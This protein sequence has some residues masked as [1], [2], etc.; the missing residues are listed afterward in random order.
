MLKSGVILEIYPRSYKSGSGGP[1]GDL[2]GIIEKLDYLQW[3]G[4]EHIWL[5]PIYP[6]PMQD[7]GY[8]VTDYYAIHEM[9]GTLADFD[10]LVAKARARGIGIIMDLVVNHTSIEHEWFR[11]A[12]SSPT[13]PYRDRYIFRSRKEDGR[14]PNNHRSMFGGTAWAPVPGEAGVY[15][16]H[17]F[18]TG[19]ADLNYSHPDVLDEM[20]RIMRYWYDRGVRGIRVDVVYFIG[21]DPELPDEPLNPHWDGVDPYEELSHTYTQF[22]PLMFRLM[23]Q[24][25]DVAAEYGDRFVIYEAYP[26]DGTDHQL[27]HR[28]YHA[29]DRQHAA[30]FHFGLFFAKWTAESIKHHVEGFLAGLPDGSVPIWNVSN[31]DQHRIASRVGSRQATV[32]MALILTLPGVPTLYY[33]DE[34]GMTNGPYIPP[35]EG[36]DPQVTRFTRDVVRTPMQWSAGE[37][38]GFTQGAEPWLRPNADFRERNV[39]AQ[40][41][42]EESMLHFTRRLIALRKSTPAL[43]LGSYTPLESDNPSVY[44]F[45]RVLGAVSVT[46][47]LNFTDQAQLAR[48]PAQTTQLLFS[49]R[50]G[51]GIEH[52][53]IELQP[54]EVMVLCST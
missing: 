22:Q 26:P 34:I 49:R 50:Q 30:P 3:L 17:T 19:Q 8:D 39:D 43:E 33:G 2:R 24:L 40:R 44:A 29:L 31:H 37:S 12:L 52:S 45:G 6:S 47:L 16:Y 1:H 48:V 28:M 15:Y 11:Q 54:N 36:E 18:A 42:D 53:A 7:G 9:Y 23:R 27:Y 51:A 25:C 38:A 46:V 14:L 13:N 4:V 21:K 20:R 5:P 10:E 41:R 32:A 35:G